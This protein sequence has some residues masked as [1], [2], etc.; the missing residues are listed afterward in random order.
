MT[1]RITCKICRR[2]GFSVC[3][4]QNCA[5]K[6][7]PYPPGV[8]GRSKAGSRR[9]SAS[10][11]YGSQLKEKQKVKFLYGLREKQFGNLV[12]KAIAAKSAETSRRIIELLETRLDNVVYR[13]GFATSRNAARQMV[14]HGHILVD[15]KRTTIPSRQLKV[16][17][18]VSLRPQSL[19]RGIFRDLDL[20]LKKSQIPSWLSLDQGKRE[21]RI[22]ALPS[23]A[24]VDTGANLNSVIEFYSR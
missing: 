24:E 5:L 11:E 14:G 17:K 8:H 7:K 19:D 1:S 16:G 21:G 6:R 20:R 12:S 3:G 18:I 23:S 15:G 22:V 13:L 2:L 4:R 9:R 10:S